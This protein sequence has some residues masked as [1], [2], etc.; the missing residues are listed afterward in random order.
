MNK[1]GDFSKR[2]LEDLEAAAQRGDGQAANR[3]SGYYEFLRRDEKKARYWLEQAAALHYK[4]AILSLGNLLVESSS[5]A[6]RQRGRKLLSE[7]DNGSRE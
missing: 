7:I 5:S 1:T 6:E 4:P 3:L 2:E